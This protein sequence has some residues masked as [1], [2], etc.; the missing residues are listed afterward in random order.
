MNWGICM[1]EVQAGKGPGCATVFAVAWTTC[2]KSGSGWTRRAE[3]SSVAAHL[4]LRSSQLEN[5]LG[6]FLTSRSAAR[7]ESFPARVRFRQLPAMQEKIQFVASLAN[8]QH[9]VKMTVKFCQNRSRTFC[10]VPT[11]DRSIPSSNASRVLASDVL[12]I[13]ETG[14]SSHYR[15]ERRLKLCR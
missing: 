3:S 14:V 11:G 5:P 6:P 8:S 12:Y 7:V 15:D 13:L 9:S 1:F 10:K 2:T 4:S